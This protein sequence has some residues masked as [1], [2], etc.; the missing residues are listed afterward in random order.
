VR[1]HYNRV[2]AALKI[3]DDT[4][5]NLSF[6]PDL[7]P[8]P[9]KTPQ[10]PTAVLIAR[11]FDGIAIHSLLNIRRLF[12]SEFK[13]LVIVS[14][15]V[16]DSGQFK[17]LE[18]I[19]DLRRSK[20]DDLK[21]LA[22][23]ANCVGWYAEHRYSLGVDLLEELEKLCRDV[24]NDFPKSVFFAGSLV[25]EQDRFFGCLLHNQTPFALQRRLYFQGHDMMILPI[26]VF[27]SP[28]T[29]TVHLTQARP[30]PTM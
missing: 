5:I 22:E 29:E 30:Q 18:E 3:L 25:F 20:E 28:R 12:P 17:G 21:S 15:G 2:R 27:L 13:N 19:E 6:R 8:V 1:S 10:G 23:F 9:P 11:A 16:I 14:V 24:A 26:R 4:L 7:N